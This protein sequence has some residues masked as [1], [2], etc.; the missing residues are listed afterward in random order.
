[1]KAVTLLE[2]GRLTST[3]IAEEA[4]PGPAEALVAVRRVGICGTDLHAYHGRQ[5]FFSYPRILGHEL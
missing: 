1:L 3:S 4:E 2:P 5:P